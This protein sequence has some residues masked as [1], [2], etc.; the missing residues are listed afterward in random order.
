MATNNVTGFGFVLSI[1]A[2]NTFP[3]G[4]TF[5]QASDDS[6][7]VDFPA[8]KFGD[9]AMGVNGDAIVWARATMIPMNL[10]VIPGSDDDLNLQALAKA[11]RVSQGKSSTNDIITATLVYPDGSIASLSSGVIT[12]GQFGK[13]IGSNGRL[14][15]HTYQ[16]MFQN[17]N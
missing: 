9:A 14:K 15:T 10:T 1:I 5:T 3:T 2:S 4:F 17:V 6:D 13:G 11:N 7:A 8:V 12:D 16:F